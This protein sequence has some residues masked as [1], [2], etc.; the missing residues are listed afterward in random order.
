MNESLTQDTSE[1]WQII[2]QMVLPH[3][4]LV[5]LT[6]KEYQEVVHQWAVGGWAGGRIQDAVHLRCAQKADCDRIYTF[7]VKDFR[8]FASAGLSE[9][10]AA[11]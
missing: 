5:T 11:P 1:A 3:M 9:K 7:N 10:I 4:E 8:S 6:P 2:E